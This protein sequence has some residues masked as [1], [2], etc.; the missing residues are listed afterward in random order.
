MKVL[1]VHKFWRKVGG[2][3]VY[4]QDVARILKNH[5]NEVKIFTTDFNAEGSRDIFP[6]D[7]NVI[8]GESF[9]YLKGHLLK[10]VKNIPQVIY[11]KSS[12]E[13]FRKLLREFR[14]DIVH[15]FAIYITI[16]PSILDACRE[17]GIPV[18]MS[19]NDYKHICPNYRLFHHGRICEDCKG[20]KFYKAVINNCCKH[21]FAVSLISA[22][23]SYTHNYL[24]IYKKNVSA[25]LFESRFML[26]KTEEFWG[27]GAAHLEFLGKPFNATHYDLSKGDGAYLLFLGRLSDEKGVDILLQ[28]MKLVP[29]AKLKIAGTGSHQ[30]FLQ[31]MATQQ[32]ISNVEFIGSRYGAELEELFTNCR[33]MV[34]P[35]LWHENFP[36][37]MMEAFARGK[38]VVGSNMVGIP[39]YIIPGETGYV[40]PSHDA[41]ALAGYIS[42]LWNH[43]DKAQ[44][45]GEKAKK[46]A[47]N[48]FNDEAF[49]T[50]LGEIYEKITGKVIKNPE[51]SQ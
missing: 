45:M 20:G 49:Y 21:S 27:K 1:L 35:S 42:D 23:E 37:V 15:V 46:M 17:E 7:E 8:F 5:G 10:R 43:P 12:K 40:F 13:Q 28:A 25:F 29:E 16:T 9:D 51:F 14:P 4:F 18:V 31:K 36:Y 44:M 11:S 34:V 19:C 22:V 6:R 41:I 48:Q 38:A 3:E 50:R 26:N 33:F 2:A 39:E 30:K 24:D 32:N 47:D